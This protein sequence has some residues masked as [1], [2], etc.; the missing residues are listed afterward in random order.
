[1]ENL[2]EY[3]KDTLHKGMINNFEKDGYLV[4][5]LFFIKDDQPVLV[6]IENEML[7]TPE[8]KHDLSNM[9]R[10]ICVTPNV[11]AAGIIIEAYGAKMDKDDGLSNF[12]VDGTIK[13]SELSNK[14]DII[15]LIFSTPEGDDMI[16]YA[17]DVKNKKVGKRFSEGDA[18]STGGIFSNFF[19][20]RQN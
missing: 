9:I 4:P 6:K 1:M 3:F 13:V 20:W 8:G 5:V 12:V 18:N 15:I 2:V 11:R 7:S 16:S 10:T 17:V 19:K 14:E